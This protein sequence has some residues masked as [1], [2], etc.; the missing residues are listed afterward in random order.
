MKKNAYS[1]SVH[2]GANRTKSDRFSPALHQNNALNSG[3]RAP[4]PQWRASLASRKAVVAL[5]WRANLKL[6]SSLHSFPAAD[7]QSD[8]AP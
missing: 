2:S 5:F 8:T 4:L 6:A 3:F 7:Y 1:V